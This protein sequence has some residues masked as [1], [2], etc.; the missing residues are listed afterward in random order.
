VSTGATAVPALADTGVTATEARPVEVRDQNL[1]LWPL[2]LA[3]G[4]GVMTFGIAG[5]FGRKRQHRMT[6]A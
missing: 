6:P 1:A 3:A 2:A 4:A 5:L